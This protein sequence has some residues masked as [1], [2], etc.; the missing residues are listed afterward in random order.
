[1]QLFEQVIFYIFY[2]KQYFIK[3]IIMILVEIILINV[4]YQLVSGVKTETV[5]HAFKVLK[6][7][8][9]NMTIGESSLISSV[10]K[11]SR[12]TCMAACNSNPNCLTTIYDNSKGRITN[13]FIYSRYF[14]ANEMIPSSTSMIY[15]KKLG[16][17]KLFLILFEHICLLK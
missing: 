5:Q 9:I 11:P 13:F 8:D 4:L 16:K 14:K 12:T 7:Q 17:L 10:N 1:M 2:C 6:N 15:E 3:Q